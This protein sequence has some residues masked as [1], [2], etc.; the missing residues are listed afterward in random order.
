MNSIILRISI[1]NLLKYK[2]TSFVCVFGLSLGFIAY[3]L[4]S[5]FIR[6]ETSWDRV[7]ENYDNI[8]VVQRDRGRSASAVGAN[9][10]TTYSPLIT[11]TL[12]KEFPDFDRV[13]LIHETGGR[14]LSISPDEQFKTERGLYADH[15]Y[16]DIFTYKFIGNYSSDDFREPYSIL[17]SETLAGKLFGDDQITGQNVTLDKKTELKVAGVYA[18]LPL[19]TSV[20]PEYII[21]FSTLEREEGISR[22]EPGALNGT[23]FCLMSGDSDPATVEKS[24]AGILSGFE[25][26]E[27]EMLRLSPLSKMRYYSAPDYF[28]ILWLFGLV[29][30]FI[31]LMSAF[32]Y[33]NLSMA[34]AS[35]RGKEIAIKKMSGSK[36]SGLVMQFLSETVLLSVVAVA[37]SVYLVSFLIPY[38]NSIMNTG[39]NLNFS[40]DWLFWGVLIF[41]SVV[42]GLLAGIYPAFFMS[43]NSIVNLFKGSFRSG[44]DKIKLR[45]TLVLFQFAISVFLICLSMFF[46]MHV[47]H[48]SEKDIGFRR[49]NMIY[50]QMTSSVTDRYFEDFRNRLLNEPS[51]INASM[52]KNLPFVNF[53]GGNINWE[54]GYPDDMVFYRPNRVTYDFIGNMGME[55]VEGRDFSRDYPSDIDQ[56]CIINETAARYFGWDN[57]IG[58]RL[59]NNQYTVVGVVKDYHVM[60]I[61]NPLDPVVL[62]LAPGEMSGTWVY[63]F[64]YMQGY[65][66]EAISLLTDEF[67]RDFPNDPFDIGELESAFVNE[68]AYR[69]YQTLKKSILFFTVFNIFLAITGL[70]GLVSFSTARRTK[71]IGIR[72]IN[73]SSI[74][75]VFVL[76]NREFFVLLGISLIIA[77]P[78]YWMVYNAFPGVYKLPFEPFILVY[79]A[80][81]ILVI[82]LASTGWQTWRAATRN[83]VEALRYE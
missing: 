23:T 67:S 21:S 64:R 6:Y 10:I 9:N 40:G 60:D 48:I 78:A 47:N 59:D 50:V 62:G 39:I 13:A 83:P 17:L 27:S 12:L 8:F 11:A 71:E 30:L 76:L 46:F 5:L 80:V 16:L 38:F 57:P 66:E 68:N 81:I 49:D 79:S 72:R 25:G 69:G 43:S 36:R 42:I 14:F 7:N 70:I 28:V 45:K 63:A 37:I 32:N 65:R 2:F 44:R 82:T 19:N 35:L 41:S 77:W 24:I 33:V 75:S 54:G 26:M 18:D 58:K 52:S 15:H 34:N 1:R 3:I 73:G 4:I 74:A 29:G 61:H 53:G 31:L 20:R 56:A 22:H 51:I 55:L